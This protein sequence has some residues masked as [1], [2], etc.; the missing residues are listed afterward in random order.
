MIKTS[1]QSQSPQPLPAPKMSTEERDG[2]D[3]DSESFV[4]IIYNTT[5]SKLQFYDGS[6]WVSLH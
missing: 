3:F 5:E 6:M 2:L 1:A 4:G